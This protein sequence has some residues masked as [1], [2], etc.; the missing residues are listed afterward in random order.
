[1][2]YYFTKAIV[3]AVTVFVSSATTAIAIV[4]IATL[5]CF[6]V[7]IR[8]QPYYSEKVTQVRSGFLFMTTIAALVG[9]ISVGAQGNS[10]YAGLVVMLVS[11]IPSYYFGSETA[12]RTLRYIERS[13]MQR[14]QAH[15]QQVEDIRAAKK[16]SPMYNKALRSLKLTTEEPI[17]PDPP[18]VS[19]PPVGSVKPGTVKLSAVAQAPAIIA[20]VEKPKRRMSEREKGVLSGK[21]LFEVS[22]QAK[23]IEIEPFGISS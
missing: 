10:N 12:R 5:L 22:Q 13:T 2:Y 15:W 20:V 4:F 8:T 7:L 3:I 17:L 1:L 16:A 9:L 6:V 21:T 11:L 19:V 23:A 14:L 18:L